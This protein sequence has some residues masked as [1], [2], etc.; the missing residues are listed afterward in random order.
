MM[1]KCRIQVS[2]RIASY[3]IHSQQQEQPEANAGI[4]AAQQMHFKIGSGF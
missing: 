4:R 3:L 1:A 2:L